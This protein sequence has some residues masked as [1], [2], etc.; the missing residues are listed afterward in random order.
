VKEKLLKKII[1]LITDF[2][3]D[4]YV[5]QMKGVILS[6]NK[7]VEIIDIKHN[8]KNYSIIE[9]AFLISQVYPY[10][11]KS[12]IHLAIIDPGVGTSRHS[13]IIETKNFYFIG[14]DNGLFSLAMEKEKIRRVIKINP[15]RFK[16]GSFTFQGRDLFAPIAARIS[17]GEK[18][19]NF[20]EEIKGI[21]K[22][23]VRDNSIIYIDNFGNI[24]T[25]IKKNF[26]LG[27]KLIIHYKGRKI[28]TKFV[29]AFAELKKGELGILKGSSGYLEIDKNR[30]SAATTLKAKIGEKIEID[31][32]S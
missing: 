20:G 32:F 30:N 9:G 5:A 18:A 8:V 16:D 15:S 19:I 3:S 13:L 23:K 22:L 24:I 1:T 14:P 6:I 28:K 10:F 7:E 17:L 29:K 27:E 2:H 31:K 26:P 11:P 21:K 12:S 25:T 4:L